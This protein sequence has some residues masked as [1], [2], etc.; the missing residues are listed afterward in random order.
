M[1]DLF[2]EVPQALRRADR[3]ARLVVRRGE[4]VDANF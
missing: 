3:E 1:L 2:D 4:T